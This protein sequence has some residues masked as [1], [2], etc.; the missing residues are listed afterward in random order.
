MIENGRHSVLGVRIDAVDYEA[1]VARI[2]RAAAESRPLT[3]SALAV[4]G[5]MTGALEPVHRYR[6]NQLDMLVPDG[7]PVRW[8]LNWL[9]GANL[10]DR[11]YGPRLMLE[12][13][14]AA[15][16]RGLPVFLFGGNNSLLADLSRRLVASYPALEIA[17]TRASRFRT[18]SAEE[19]D[20]LVREIHDSGARLAFVG[21]GCPRQ[22]VF[23]YEL[24]ERLTMPLLA[25]GAA[26][27][28]HAGQLRQAP[29]WM[30]DVGLEWLFRL[31]AEPTRLWRRYLVLNPLYLLLVALE[32]SGLCQF[33]PKKARRPE[34]EVCYG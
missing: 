4:H 26:F 30:Q 19:R 12:T 25:V 23:V 13:C 17:G 34:N 10:P 5:L 28:F 21:L 24:R 9:H 2:V 14:A 8:A 29:S 11:V 32:A 22:E 16:E 15:A 18:L 1:T 3:V 20:E 7:Q 6:L 33:D 31:A 27:N